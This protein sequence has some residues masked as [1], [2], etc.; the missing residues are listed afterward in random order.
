[1]DEDPNQRLRLVLDHSVSVQKVIVNNFNLGEP[2]RAG[3][4][5]RET[6]HEEVFC[7]LP[8]EGP[9]ESGVKGMKGWCRNVRP[10]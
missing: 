9:L 8:Y 4:K 7:P 1:M 2:S 10:T 3:N 5:I 6:E